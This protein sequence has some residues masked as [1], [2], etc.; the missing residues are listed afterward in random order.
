MIKIYQINT[1]DMKPMKTPLQQL[2]Q[3]LKTN[4]NYLPSKFVFSKIDA[5]LEEEKSQILAAFLS[6][7]DVVDK[8]TIDEAKKTYDEIYK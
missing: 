8:N 5:L 7:K 4:E 2:K 1:N 3:L 6:F